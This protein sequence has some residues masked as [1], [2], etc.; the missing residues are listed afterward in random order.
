MTKLGELQTPVS[1]FKPGWRRTFAQMIYT[2]YSHGCKCVQT[3]K[4]VVSDVFYW[5]DYG[6]V[7]LLTTTLLVY[8]ALG[9]EF[10]WGWV[11]VK[12][13]CSPGFDRDQSIRRGKPRKTLDVC[14]DHSV[15]FLVRDC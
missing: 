9:A 3:F 10:M 2:D 11:G 14:I 6:T 8:A 13:R 12:G 15:F 4:L 5:L 7:V 1:I